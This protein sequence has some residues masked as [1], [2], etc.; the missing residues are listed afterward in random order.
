MCARK[1]LIGPPVIFS[2]MSQASHNSLAVHAQVMVP[3]LSTGFITEAHF[4]VGLTSWAR[5]EAGAGYGRVARRRSGAD[6][7]LAVTPATLSMILELPADLGDAPVPYL[8]GGGGGSAAMAFIL[9]LI[10]FDVD[11]VVR[12]GLTV[13]AL[14]AASLSIAYSIVRYRFLDAK[15]IARRSILFG[16][17]SGLAL[18]VLEW[19]CER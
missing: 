10:G 6:N 9:N 8:R 1:L 17:V 16:A 13:A 5:L 18:G 4:S 19:R 7:A 12:I 14:A 15:V 3:W 11:P 2:S